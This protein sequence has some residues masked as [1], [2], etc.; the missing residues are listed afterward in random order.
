MAQYRKTPPLA[1][2]GNADI[3]S[4]EV[5]IG[6]SVDWLQ[7]NWVRESVSSVHGDGDLAGSTGTNGHSLRPQ[8]LGKRKPLALPVCDG[9]SDKNLHN[10]DVTG[11][12]DRH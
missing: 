3:D 9:L 11:G 10:C 5:D 4:R 2:F 7:P 6:A 8:R 1:R 12:T